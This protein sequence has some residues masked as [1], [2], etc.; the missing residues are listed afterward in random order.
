VSDRA[1]RLA[2]ATFAAAGA[3][4][5][6]YLTVAKL[7]GAPIACATRGCETVAR[8]RYGAVGGVPVAA[9]GVASFLFVL[10]SALVALD[11]L[12]VAAAA[13]AIGS[14]IVAASLLY[15]QAAVLHAYC[16]WCLASDAIFAA[17]LV[18]TLLRAL[19]LSRGEYADRRGGSSHAARRAGARARARPAAPF[20]RSRRTG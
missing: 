1:L 16:Q 2:V 19:R 13:V 18:L 7:S 8:S 6:S 20:P 14:T 9:F 12:V 10:V 17:L 4:I 3:A 11:R 15:V 5:A